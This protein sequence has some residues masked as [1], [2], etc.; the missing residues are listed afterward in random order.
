MAES[1]VEIV[2]YAFTMLG[3]KRINSLEEDT[4][5][6]R[7]ANA[8]Y[9]L[10]RD[11]CLSEHE[12]NFATQRVS[13]GSALSDTPLFDY[14][15]QFSLPN[16]CLRVIDTNLN[17]NDPWK[18]EGRVLLCDSSSVYIKYVK[19]ETSPTKYSSSFV[20]YFATRLAEK[21]AFPLTGSRSL[22]ADM[23]ERAERL[24]KSGFGVD[25]VEG[26][27]DYPNQD[28]WNTQRY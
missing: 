27:N 2:N 20:E 18:V 8:V 25:S 13:L 7:S 26:S 16:D 17:V 3:V 21:L 4:E 12:W 14:D 1:D 6:A 19:K 9:T 15:Y 10:V 28:N 23:F 22:E 11:M 5:Q 24:K